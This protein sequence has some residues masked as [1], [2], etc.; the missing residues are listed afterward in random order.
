MTLAGEAPI[1][2]GAQQ[3]GRAG[4]GLRDSLLV[5]L[6]VLLWL[7]SLSTL[8]QSDMNIYILPAAALLILL[9]DRVMRQPLVLAS[10]YDARAFAAVIWSAIALSGLAFISAIYADVPQRVFRVIAG[11]MFGV[12]IVGTMVSLHT[13]AERLQKYVDLFIW[14]A[15]LSSAYA[16]AA[17][18]VPAL[19]SIAFGDSDRTAAFFKNPNQFGMALSLAVPLVVAS[20][21]VDRNKLFRLGQLGTI[22]LGLAFSG[23]KTNLAASAVL[24]FAALFLAF[25]RSGMAKRRPLLMALTVAIAI[26]GA[27]V[28]FLTLADLNPRAQKLLMATA[29]G[30]TISSWDQRMNLWRISIADGF[31]HPL[32]GVGVGERVGSTGVSH[33]HNVFIDYLRTLGFPGLTLLMISVGGA[34][35]VALGS[36]LGRAPKGT[37]P[38]QAALTACLGLSAVGY[39]FTNQFSDSFGPSTL[40]LFWIVLGLLF[41]FRRYQRQA[42]SNGSP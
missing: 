36:I 40:P 34:L 20:C 5:L 19:S 8:G 3:R 27:I 38:K 1:A 7:P 11:Q 18:F 23:S 22:Y 29:S 6:M 25:L 14:G 16:A 17:Y 41:C 31:G 28:A 10:V 42:A 9:F 39:V 32:T 33:S 15:T 12:A 21:V 24:A 26:L 13:P 37:P 4:Y 35:S 30:D 2:V